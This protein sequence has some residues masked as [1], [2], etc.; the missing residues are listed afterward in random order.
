MT[1]RIAQATKQTTVAHWRPPTLFALWAGGT[2]LLWLLYAFVFVQT[3]GS[4]W[5]EAAG[6][7]LANVFPLALLA[8]ATRE[9][10]KSYI[11]PASVPFQ[12][13]AHAVLSI[14]F[15]TAWYA[16]VLVLLAFLSGLRGGG[17]AVSGFAGPAFTWQVFQGLVLYALVAAICYAVRGGREAAPVSFVEQA[18][19]FERYLTKSGD[20]FQPVEV[21]DIVTIKGA[22]DYSEV[23][24]I[25][26]RNHLVRMSLG[27]FEQRLD[28]GRFIR[29]HRS[30]IIN[31]AR[32]GRLEPAGSGRLTAHMANGDS[33]EVS[34]TGAQ[35]LRRFIV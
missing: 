35:L 14:M 11:M 3:A 29:V 24:T 30:T 1:E 6:L 10:L 18:A 12:V 4:G 20:E 28:K 23:A 8:I 32:L 25:D 33:V 21:A 15:A 13:I 2:A 7:G 27:E 17:F 26:A 16:I 5:A 34:R 31:L 19:P 22:Q 9:V